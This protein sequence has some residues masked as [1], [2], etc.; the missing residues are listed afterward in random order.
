MRMVIDHSKDSISRGRPDN[1]PLSPTPIDCPCAVLLPD[2]VLDLILGNAPLN[3]S[4]LGMFGPDEP[5]N[6]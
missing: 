6:P 5:L 2:Q 1:S 3:S 4:H